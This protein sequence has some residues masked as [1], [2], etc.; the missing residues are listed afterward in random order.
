MSKACCNTSVGVLISDAARAN[1][2]M[3][4]R[5]D[6]QGV[7]PVAGHALD[8]HPGW[9]AAAIAEVSE[10]IGLE[11]EFLTDT[12]VG[13][14]RPNECTRSDKGA[15][16]PGHD[17]RIYRAEVSGVLA[18]NPRE[19]RGARWY[20]PTEVQRLSGR[21]IDYAQGHLTP[22]DWDAEPGLEPV[23]LEW[24]ASLGEVAASRAEL[25]IVDQLTR[26]QP[27]RVWALEFVPQ[28][29]RQ[30]LYTD[31]ST[32]RRMALSSL[33]AEEDPERVISLQVATT[34]RGPRTAR[35]L[36]CGRIARFSPY[37]G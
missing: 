4:T 22:Q 31:V 9:R 15:R 6:G 13:G 10:E 16:G 23:W 18:P 20:S 33:L 35:L 8:S 28:E 12:G 37:E 17:W 19:T 30:V 21:T 34:P 29:G 5:A 32:A 36:R 11:V 25:A 7:A 3:I 24:L 26:A 27:V 1:H 2:L 14:W